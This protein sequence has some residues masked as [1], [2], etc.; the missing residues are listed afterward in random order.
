MSRPLGRISHSWPPP[1]AFALR[2]GYPWPPPFYRGPRLTTHAIPSVK[3]GKH[4]IKG[5]GKSGGHARGQ[6]SHACENQTLDL[7]YTISRVSS[8]W[9]QITCA[10][11]VTKYSV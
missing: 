2:D 6:K 8:T 11:E 5:P 3:E 4:Q 7:D 10:S 1:S 9:P